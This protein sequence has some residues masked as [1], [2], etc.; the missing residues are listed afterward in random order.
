MI[1]RSASLSGPRL[2][3]MWAPSGEND[4]YPTLSEVGETIRS[5]LPS[6][7]TKETEDRVP[8]VVKAIQSPAGDHVTVYTPLATFE[9]RWGSPPAT[10]PT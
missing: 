8:S 6:G 10:S 5:S 1:Q 9:M 4:G 7:R 2:T 3:S